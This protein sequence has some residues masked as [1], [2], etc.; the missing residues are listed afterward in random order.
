MTTDA[1][2]HNMFSVETALRKCVIAHTTRT[3]GCDVVLALLRI[4]VESKTG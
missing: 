3:S 4:A 1:Q 2:F